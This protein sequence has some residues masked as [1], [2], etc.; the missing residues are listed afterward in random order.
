MYL[1]TVGRQIVKLLQTFFGRHTQNSIDFNEAILSSKLSLCVHSTLLNDCL[2]HKK[3]Q[4]CVFWIP[5]GIFENN[6]HYAIPYTISWN[7]KKI[8]VNNRQWC[9]VRWVNIGCLNKLIWLVHRQP[10]SRS[11]VEFRIKFK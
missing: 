3:Y 7:K 11:N 1:E 2:S 9:R 6:F 5:Q 8:I 4:D 10:S